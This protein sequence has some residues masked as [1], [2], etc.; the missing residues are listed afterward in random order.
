MGVEP[1]CQEAPRSHMKGSQITQTIHTM[2]LLREVILKEVGVDV[3]SVTVVEGVTIEALLTLDNIDGVGGKVR[4]V[5][6]VMVETE[7]GMIAELG[8]D[9]RTG[10]GDSD[11]R[12]RMVLEEMGSSL[13]V[14]NLPI[15]EVMTKK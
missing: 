7:L 1:Q 14:Q 6:V 11:R 9:G 15:P 8:V 10:C 4:R 3:V 13:I 2:R 5:A 12:G